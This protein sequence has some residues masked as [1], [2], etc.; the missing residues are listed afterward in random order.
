[1]GGTSSTRLETTTRIARLPEG[2][3]DY[4]WLPDGRVLVGQGARLLELPRGAAEFREE[5]IDR[6]GPQRFLGGEVVVDLGLVGVDALGDR[7]GRR[8][9][10][11]LG[12]ELDERGLEQPLAEVV[13]GS[14]C[15]SH[16]ARCYRS[17]I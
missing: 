4:A 2:V 15:T 12:A 17:I 16:E 8:P 11:P 6:G 10:E 7:S 9:V 5:V 14:A 1:M 3:E 13:P